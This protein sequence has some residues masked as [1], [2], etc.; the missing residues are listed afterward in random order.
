MACCS[1]RKAIKHKQKE[2]QKKAWNDRSKSYKMK[3]ED[4]NK[5]LFDDLA[6]SVFGLIVQEQ[7]VTGVELTIGDRDHIR[8]NELSNIGIDGLHYWQSSN[9]TTEKIKFELSTSF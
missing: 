9:R 2:A 8:R 5:S 7:P 1:V 4:E 6:K 3:E